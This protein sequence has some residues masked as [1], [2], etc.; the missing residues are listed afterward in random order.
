[1]HEERL[2]YAKVGKVLLKDEYGKSGPEIKEKQFQLLSLMENFERKF[3]YQSI[4]KAFET[5]MNRKNRYILSGNQTKR[6]NNILDEPKLLLTK[7]RNKPISQKRSISAIKLYDKNSKI[8]NNKSKV[9]PKK[10]M[11][12]YYMI[13]SLIL[14]T[15]H[16]TKIKI[17][18]HSNFILKKKIKNI[19]RVKKLYVFLQIVKM[20]I[21]QIVS[22]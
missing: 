12:L 11:I 16:L 15:N 8:I 13:I 14:K 21:L 9:N 5:A 3:E 2:N 19:K 18:F 20:Q 10:N 6:K 7:L 17:Y 1:M 4:V 22:I